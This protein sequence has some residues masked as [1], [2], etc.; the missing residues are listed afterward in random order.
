MLFDHE[1]QLFRGTDVVRER[2]QGKL[3]E[4]LHKLESL[5]DLTISSANLMGTIP[6]SVFLAPLVERMF[7]F[8]LGG[9]YSESPF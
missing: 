4:N 9:V 5:I 2:V 3:S 1:S 7:V 6:R 8:P